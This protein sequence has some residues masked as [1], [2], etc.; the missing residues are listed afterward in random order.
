MIGKCALYSAAYKILGVLLCR[1]G[2]F[3]AIHP[4]FIEV[5]RSKHLRKWQRKRN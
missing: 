5:I 4:D 2:K 1:Y 3:K